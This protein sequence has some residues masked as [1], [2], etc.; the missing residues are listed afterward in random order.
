V[1]LVSCEHIGTHD[2]G[3][4]EA[5]AWEVRAHEHTSLQVHVCEVPCMSQSQCTRPPHDVDEAHDPKEHEQL[6]GGGDGD[7]DGCVE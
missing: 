2:S 7:G 6:P 1:G 5:G 4:V 3:V